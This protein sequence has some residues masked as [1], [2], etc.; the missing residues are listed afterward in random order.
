MYNKT[1]L[2]GNLGANP[3]LRTTPNGKSVCNFT[4]ATNDRFSDKPEWHRIV[5]WGKVAEACAQHLA[6]GR[7]VCV[8]GKIQY[9]KWEDR[10]GQTRYTTEIVASNVT[11]LPGGPRTSGQEA[12]NSVSND[13][14]SVEQH[15]S[16]GE[17]APF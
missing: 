17:D 15:V 11:F 1:T 4:V 3:E 8:E 13:A 7:T 10:E 2:I 16:V 9:R 5:V 14:E 12:S 6:K